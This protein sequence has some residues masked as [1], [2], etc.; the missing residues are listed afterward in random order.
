MCNIGVERNI[1][2]ELIKERYA[3]KDLTETHVLSP[4]AN[5]TSSPIS[6]PAIT[7]GTNGNPNANYIDLSEMESTADPAAQQTKPV[8]YLVGEKDKFTA[9]C[10]NTTN[11][12]YENIKMDNRNNHSNAFIDAERFNGNAPQISTR[13]VASKKPMPS[14]RL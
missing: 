9:I 6:S 3:I 12:N 14:N 10:E 5:G 8:N 4:E 13:D 2:Q 7:N 1:G 11:E